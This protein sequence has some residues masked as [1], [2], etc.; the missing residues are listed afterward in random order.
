MYNIEI[1]LDALNLYSKFKSYSKTSRDVQKKYNI[2]V[3]RQT[4]M[5]WVKWFGND[6]SKVCKTRINKQYIDSIIESKEKKFDLTIISDVLKLVNHDPF[7]SRNDIKTSILNKHNIKL[8]DKKISLIFKK[9]KLTRKKA[10]CYIV[11][12]IEY[13]DVLIEKR[14][15]YKSEINKINIDKII[16]ID[17]KI[18]LLATK[19]LFYNVKKLFIFFYKKIKSDGESGFNT[20]ISFTKGLSEKGRPINVPINQKK[21]KNHSLISAVTTDKIIHY[22]IHES[23]VN[24]RHFLLK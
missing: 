13:L 8:S 9:L 7:I 10:K 1:V 20:L 22:E 15:L 24:N 16:S 19:S 4:I 5:N 23:G 17:D 12:S 21:V 2:S 18:N 11:K 3:T 14:K 6:M